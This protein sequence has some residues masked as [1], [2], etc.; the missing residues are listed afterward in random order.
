MADLLRLKHQD[1]AG[2]ILAGVE[3]QCGQKE[4]TDD[5]RRSLGTRGFREARPFLSFT[6]VGCN[7]SQCPAQNADPGS[8]VSC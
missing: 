8:A 2:N 1:V 4:I 7:L 5:P 6:M 3:V